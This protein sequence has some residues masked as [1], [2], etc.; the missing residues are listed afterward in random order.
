MFYRSF[1][2]LLLS[3]IAATHLE[4]QLNSIVP[5]APVKDFRFP[6][7]GENGY[8]QWVLRGKEGIYDSAKQIRVEEMLLRLYTGDERMA[9]EMT[10]NSPSA[11]LRLDANQAE[12]DQSIQ[13]VGGNFH[14]TGKGWTWDGKLK[15]I[16]ILA[17]TRVEFKESIVESMTGMNP[18]SV[19]QPS[20]D[21]RSQRLRL[22]TSEEAYHFNFEGDVVVQSAN[23][24]LTAGALYAQA[25]TPSG[26]TQHQDIKAPSAVG[27]DSLRKIHAREAVSL[28]HSGRTVR[29]NRAEFDPR[30]GL[31]HFEGEAVVEVEGAYLTGASIR[32]KHGVMELSG[33]DEFGRA[34]M[35]I[36]QVGG[37]GIQGASS[38]G[39]DTSVHADHIRMEQVTDHHHFAFTGSVDVQSGS[40]QLKSDSM[41]VTS[42]HAVDV[43]SDDARSMQVGAVQQLIAKGDVQIDR[44]GQRATSDE[45]FFY[46]QTGR[47]K[48]FGNPI[49][50]RQE[51]QLRGAQMELLEGEAIVRGGPEE[52]QLVE[53]TLPTLPN[54]GYPSVAVDPQQTT[55]RLAANEQRP[56]LVR[57]ESLHMSE[58]GD[59]TIFKFDKSVAVSATNLE[60]SCQRMDVFTENNNANAGDASLMEQFEVRRIEAFDTVRIEQEGR[61]ATAN[62]ATIVPALGRLT[63]E[64][65]AV[66]VDDSGRVSGHRV[67]V[68]Q[69]QR[70][71]I[72]EAGEGQRARVTLP[73][74]ADPSN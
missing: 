13:I 48:L 42:R 71:A 16:V 23:M 37:L 21:I 64:G 40:L 17:D 18:L 27:V 73:E 22:R 32:S 29:A 50:N 66:V 45:A 53:V 62:A 56:T 65:D 39:E 60:A 2:S 6:Q 58:A 3:L 69:G 44:N 7:F 4:A 70:R 35:R 47:A 72:V 59:L 43:G 36:K 52:D 14:I 11:T 12:S 74:L 55:E 5:S 46:P 49:I 24:Y 33:S 1:L 26:A 61:L 25:A 19:D 57:S 68:S 28:M 63:L 41:A 9:V 31:A 54:L 30:E 51:V 8:T 67:T 38:M 10:L 15:E 34:K 20:T